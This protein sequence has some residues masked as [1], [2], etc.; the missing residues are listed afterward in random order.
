MS[1][2]LLLVVAGEL[3]EA[4]LVT[5]VA[6]TVPRIRPKVAAEKARKEKP[7]SISS[8]AMRRAAEAETNGH[9]PASCTG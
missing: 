9:S 3:K 2:A 1:Q 8:M 5:R 6:M 4:G 7:L